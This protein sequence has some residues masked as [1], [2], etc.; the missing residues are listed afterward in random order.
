MNS[1]KL[2]L[3]VLA[4]AAAGALIGILFAP[5]KGSATRKKIVRKGEDYAD[6]VTEKFNDFLESLHA[7]FEKVKGDVSDFAEQAKDKFEDNEFSETTRG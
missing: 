5:D 2:L 3:G 6:A 4:G 1:G 7:K